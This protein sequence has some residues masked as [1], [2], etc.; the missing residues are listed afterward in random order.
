MD[1][2]GLGLLQPHAGIPGGQ[3]RHRGGRRRRSGRRPN[4]RRHF[5]LLP[6]PRHRNG[7]SPVHQVSILLF[8]YLMTLNDNASS[9]LER[10][11]TVA[12]AMDQSKLMRL[13]SFSLMMLL[14]R[15]IMMQMVTCCR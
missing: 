5:R 14:K 10:K 7:H 4:P 8:G 2:L 1:G 13:S 9:L 15:L 12:V 3:H 11:T 6:L